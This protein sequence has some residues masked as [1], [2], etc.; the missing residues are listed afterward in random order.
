MRMDVFVTKDELEQVKTEYKVSGMYLSGG[1]P[2][3]NPQ[4][5]VQELNKKYNMPE[6]TGLDLSNGEFV[7]P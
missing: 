5:A 1:K 2:M 7:G 3:G 4:R 6:G